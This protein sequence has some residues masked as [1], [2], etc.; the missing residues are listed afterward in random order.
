MYLSE[1]EMNLE[2]LRYPVG[3]Y[4][5]PSEVSPDEMQSARE[6]IKAF[7]AKIAQ[8]VAG[9]SATQLDTPYR[10]D[11]W[12]IRQVVHHCADS[13]M[14]AYVRFKLTLTEE[15]PTIKPYKEA[16]WAMLPDSRMEPSV[17]LSLIDHIH[18]RWGTIMEHM[19]PEQWQLSFYHPENGKTQTLAQAS[20]LYSWHCQHHL[21]H[22]LRL[23]ES[24][25]WA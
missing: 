19:T 14:N 11:G 21:S 5:M 16:L 24:K 1:M 3:R 6:I 23:K 18:H 8:A 7:P 20:Q 2:A 10:P 15:T 9:L 25:G 4:T 17:S 13:H 22:I 12:T